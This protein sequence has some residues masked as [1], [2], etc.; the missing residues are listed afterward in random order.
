[1]NLS[2]STRGWNDLPWEDQ[3][4]D[5]EEYHF[6]GIEVYNLSR[7]PRYT[8]R[9][10]PFHQYHIN[11]TMRSLRDRNLSVSCLDT[12]IDLSDGD[13]SPEEFRL[14][15]STAQLIRS[16]YVSVCAL[17]DHEETVCRNLSLVLSL[18]E[19]TNVTAD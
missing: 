5:A 3:L 10:G 9:S 2:F 12:S 16:P 1:M 6:Q 11:E 17:S 19:G 15:F 18:I 13:I 14:L 7:I 8:D 4:R